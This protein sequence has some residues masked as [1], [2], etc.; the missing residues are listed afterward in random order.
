MPEAEDLHRAAGLLALAVGTSAALAPR[1]LL[2]GFGIA[3]SEVTGAAE[4]GW[5]MFGIRTALVGGAVVAGSRG[6]RTAVIPVQL[7]DQVTFVLAG[8]RPGVPVRA[9]RM[10]QGVSGVLVALSAA[11]HRAG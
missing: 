11:A 10:A 8:R 2:R 9:V 1:P 3:S 5:R 4:L 7:A 6:A